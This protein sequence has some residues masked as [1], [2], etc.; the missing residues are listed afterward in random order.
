MILVLDNCLNLQPSS[1]Q[2]SG[3]LWYPS[4]LSFY[5]PLASFK[6]LVFHHL[7]HPFLRSCPRPCFTNNCFPF[8]NVLPTNYCISPFQFT[9]PRTLLQQLFGFTKTSNV[10]TTSLS[11]C[12]SPH[13]LIYCLSELEYHGWLSPFPCV[14]HQLPLCFSLW[15][16]FLE[17]LYPD[18][19]RWQTWD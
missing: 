14:R 17:K 13:D 16:T 4:R 18:S 6:G 11:Y 12:H 15:H 1:C 19:I 5:W 7:S 3:W 10:I 9:L 8:S 2:Y